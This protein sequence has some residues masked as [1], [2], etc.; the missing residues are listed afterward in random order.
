MGSW[1]YISCFFKITLWK[2]DGIIYIYDLA[3]YKSFEYIPNYIQKVSTD[4]KKYDKEERVVTEEEGKKLA[5]KYN[6]NF[7]ETSCLR[8]QNVNEVFYFLVSEILKNDIIN[9]SKD[10]KIL[11]TIDNK[12]DANNGC[13]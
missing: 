13:W 11:W 7:F 12:Q 6:M 9:K 5:Q 8:K 2:A 1:S 10:N 3:N 4:V